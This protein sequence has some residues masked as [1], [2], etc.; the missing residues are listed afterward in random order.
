MLGELA[1]L[2]AQPS[3]PKIQL[4]RGSPGFLL[5]TLA[6]YMRAAT[7]SAVCEIKGVTLRYLRLVA[8][9]LRGG[10]SMNALHSFLLWIS[11]FAALLLQRGSTMQ[12][13]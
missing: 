13:V 4:V 2:R 7:R 1:C 6:N 5:A 12:V 10:L 11:S 8:L 3:A 9:Q